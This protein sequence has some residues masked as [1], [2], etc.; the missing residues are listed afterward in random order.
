MPFLQKEGFTFDYDCLDFTQFM[1]FDTSSAGQG[2]G[3]QPELALAIAGIDVDVR[4]L[5]S[6]I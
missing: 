3:R 6:L 2:D 1:G 5:A 4:R